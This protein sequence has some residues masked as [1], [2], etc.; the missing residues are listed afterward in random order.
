MCLFCC[1]LFYS[2]SF[3]NT[4]F[5]L[6]SRETVALYLV[7][8]NFKTRQ[9]TSYL[10]LYTLY[11]EPGLTII[12][13]CFADYNARQRTINNNATW[14]LKN[15][16]NFEYCNI[17]SQ[18]IRKHRLL[19]ICIVLAIKEWFGADTKTRYVIFE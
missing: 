5:T 4:V 11:K 7:H 3:F 19:L 9:F 18:H 2:A 8:C 17:M 1:I 10:L 13:Y 16:F 14:C 6:F 12:I 15:L